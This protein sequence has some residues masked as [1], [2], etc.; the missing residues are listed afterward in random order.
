MVALCDV[1]L[2]QS[3]T[4]SAALHPQ[5]PVLLL[6]LLLVLLPLPPLLLLRGAPARLPG[7]QL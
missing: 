5:E 6:V 3:I 4:L 2:S 7:V 1:G